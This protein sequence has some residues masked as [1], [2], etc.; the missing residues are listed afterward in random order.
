MFIVLFSVMSMAANAEVIEFTNGYFKYKLETEAK[1]AELT[2][3]SGS[4]TEVIIPESVTYEN[5][6]YS[7]TILGD[8]SF[9]G[10]SI[11]SITIP[12][13]VTS[14]GNYC[15]SA[16]TS[17][18]SVTIPSSVTSFGQGCFNYCSSL[19]SIEIPSSVTSLGGICFAGCSALLSITVDKNNK[20]YDSRENCNAIIKTSTN[21]MIQGCKTTVIPSS[22]TSL[23][24][25]CFGD[26]SSLT[27]II[28][29]S[30]VM[31][32][33]NYCF[34]RSSITSLTLPS[35][36]TN[37]GDG[38]FCECSS[39]T[40][41]DI[42]SSVMSLGESCFYKCSSLNSITIPSSVKMLEFSCF[43]DC[44]SLT[45]IK[46]PSSVE[47]LGEYCFS[48]SSITSIT[49]PSSVTSLAD[50]CFY[51]CS[52]LAS[53]TIGKSVK[54]IDIYAFQECSSL[55]SV[56]CLNS[57]PIS[58]DKTAF[59]GLDKSTMT[60]YVPKISIADYQNADNWK[61]F[62]NVEALRQRVE[63]GSAGK[64]T[65]CCDFDLDFTDVEGLKAYVATGFNHDNGSILLTRIYKI[66]S[67]T[68]VL[69]VG[70]TG[71][72]EI[73][74]ADINYTY[75]NL[76]VGTLEEM[77]VPMTSDGYTHYILA[78]GPSGVMFYK[79]AGGTLSAN[80]S[81]LR[82]PSSE[83]TSDMVKMRFTDDDPTSV[84]MTDCDKR[85]TDVMYNLKGQHI[86]KPR[87]GMYI[88]NGKTYVE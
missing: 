36:V 28:I 85:E 61:E 52:R 73:P 54:N 60:L 75:A 84:D 67:G 80:K 18:I 31:S 56:K 9:S 14:L 87:K 7:V 81:Y 50:C 66:P 15:F 10:S 72:Y 59:Q 45:S 86:Y 55:T 27:S 8:A 13:S 6:A 16:C 11:T 23:G 46:I 41:I 22:V 83:A 24:E 39:L 79:Y 30:S 38:C 43:R 53:V 48:G 17:L 57:T 35:S 21:T 63:I 29:P 74:V 20:V 64:A 12:S 65:Y 76:F 19:T 62:G 49:I 3:F 40:S 77:E 1:T 26:C 33:G 70:N 51:R 58:I 47:Y 71:T 37:L 42:P 32:L 34:C 4:Q 82:V 2:K 5:V 68:G 88:K 44:S 25:S 78:N 69:L